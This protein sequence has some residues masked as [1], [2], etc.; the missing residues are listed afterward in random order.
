[1]RYIL[2]IGLLL[3]SFSS[4]AQERDSVVKY[5]DRV[6]Y[7]SDST[8]KAAYRMKDGKQNGFFVQYAGNGSPVLIGQYINGKPTGIWKTAAGSLINYADYRGLKLTPGCG[9]GINQVKNDFHQLYSMLLTGY[10]ERYER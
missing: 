7:F 5:F 3:T 2:I 6:E 10:R 1:M 8:I 4:K 9:T